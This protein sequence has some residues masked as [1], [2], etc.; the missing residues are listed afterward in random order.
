MAFLFVNTIRKPSHHRHQFNIHV[1][2]F[3]C[4]DETVKYQR[5]AKARK[6]V[7]IDILIVCTVDNSVNLD[8]PHFV[9]IMSCWSTAWPSGHQLIRIEDMTQLPQPPS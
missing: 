8:L 9:N 3:S 2:T 1:R 5:C 4:R 6:W 7:A